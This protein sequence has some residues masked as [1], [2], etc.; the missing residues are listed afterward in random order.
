MPT[1]AP[2]WDPDPP[3]WDRGCPV[4]DA[5]AV[6]TKK[7]RDMWKWN[8]FSVHKLCTDS[9]IWSGS[10]PKIVGAT[11]ILPLK[12]PIRLFC[13]PLRD[14]KHVSLRLGPEDPGGPVA[15]STLERFFF[16]LFLARIDNGIF[17]PY[18][19]LSVT[20]RQLFSLTLFCPQSEM[21][22][23]LIYFCHNHDRNDFSDLI[24]LHSLSNLGLWSR[25]CATL[26]GAA[27][28]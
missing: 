26:D 5:T 7:R 15:R 25:D 20:W 9:G 2:V 14:L 16:V 21:R 4:L 13:W 28:R 6:Q 19:V 18:L 17:F 1:T 10:R 24:Y 22:T 12:Y 8:S 27:I 3:E 11:P 23:W